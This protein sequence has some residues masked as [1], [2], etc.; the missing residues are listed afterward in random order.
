MVLFAL[1]LRVS[2]RTDRL[3]FLK[4]LHTE[5]Q[6]HENAKSGP[7]HYRLEEDLVEKVS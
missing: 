4:S 2:L 7:F 6:K 1:I 3:F 5:V